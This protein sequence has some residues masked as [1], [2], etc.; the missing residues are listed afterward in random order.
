MIESLAFFPSSSAQN[1]GPV[2]DAMIASA[3]DQGI[4]CRADDLDCDAAL[5]WSVLWHGRMKRNRE[6]Y[7]HY[8]SLGRPVIIAEVGCL[9]RN[10]TWRV[11]VNHV[12][13]QGYYGHEQDL[14]PDRPRRLGLS[15]ARSIGSAILIACQ[16]SKSLQMEGI[17]NA[18]QW[19]IDQI[20]Q[21]RR[22]SD[23]PIVVRP[24]P[25]DSLGYFCLPRDV[26]LQFPLRVPGTYDSFNWSSDY[27]AVINHN[28]GPGVQAARD[29]VRPVVDKSS[30]AWPVSVAM[31]HIELPYDVD[32]DDWFVRLCHTEYTLNELADGLW[33]RRICSAL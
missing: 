2:L 5:I 29:G 19:V 25:R 32:R 8:R 1:S 16:H 30:L 12:T 4:T 9:I 6:I 14:D 3:R 27:H 28:S 11:A 33:L 26:T 13:R 23:R 10:V 18:T 24:H 31:E 17:P 22:Y 21:V 7:Q 15:L 20:R